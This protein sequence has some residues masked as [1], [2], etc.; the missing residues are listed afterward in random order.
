MQSDGS[1]ERSIARVACPAFCTEVVATS[2]EEPVLIF[3]RSGPCAAWHCMQLTLLRQWSPR[4][5][6]LCASLPAWQDKHVSEA[7]L[8]SSLL[9]ETIFVTSPPDST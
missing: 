2:V 4:R 6:L 8:A 1:A 7:V 3:G 5:K 9:N